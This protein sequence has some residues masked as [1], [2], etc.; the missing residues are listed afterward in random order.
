MQTMRL[1]FQSQ[2]LLNNV[3]EDMKFDKQNHLKQNN[4]T[5][6]IEMME[7]IRENER[8]V[9]IGIKSRTTGN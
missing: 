1:D 3:E 6:Y 2:S 4:P 5:N 9:L 8:E 7:N